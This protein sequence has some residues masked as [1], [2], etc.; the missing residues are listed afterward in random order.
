MIKFECVVSPDV[1]PSAR[2]SDGLEL[3]GEG[4]LTLIK[5]SGIDRG[6][7][8]SDID[9]GHCRFAQLHVIAQRFVTAEEMETEM[10]SFSRIAQHL[11]QTS[12]FMTSSSV[13]GVVSNEV[14]SS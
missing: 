6:C 14:G 9:K 13:S 2:F 5:H 10:R 8:Q 1:F 12:V 7:E 4:K 3:S 11:V